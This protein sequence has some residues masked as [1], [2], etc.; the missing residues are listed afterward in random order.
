MQDV[1]ALYEQN[2]ARRG[3][4]SD[5]SQWRAVERLQQLHEEWTAYKARRNNKLKRLLV[6]PALPKGV[7]LW[8]AVGRG[9]SFLMDSFYLC[10]PLVRKR[11][12]HFHHFMREIHREL[13]ELRGTEDPIAQV[14]ARTARRCRLICFDEFH[15]ADIADAMILRRYL[16]QVMERGVVFC[17]TS[18]YRPDQL[19]AN[20][21]QR[22]RFLPAIELIKQ[23][24]DVVE[25][26]SGVDYRRRKMERLKVYHVG[27]GSEAELER[28]FSD[29][30]DVE[31]EKHPLDVEGRAIA[32]RRRAGGL[33]WFDFEVLCGG[34]RS[35]SDYVDLAK[36]F[37]TVILS[38]VAKMSS[39]NAD[40]ARRFTWLIDVFYDER[41]KLIVSAEAQPEELYPEGVNSAEFARA[42]SRLHEMQS[43]DYLQSERRRSSGQVQ[44][45]QAH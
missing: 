42:A 34:P 4:V 21:L 15:V 20:G 8:G 35:Y 44:G 9:K 16:E 30:R 27:A 37:H 31:E 13:D 40:A 17:M 3:F 6:R 1:I 28:I 14:A 11:R 18:N 19:Y 43:A 26:D 38:G 2:L 22:E 24:L 23:R 45:I 33:V 7:Y 32:Y 41:V 25:V 5:S 29:L 39:R 36:R 10:V 12:V